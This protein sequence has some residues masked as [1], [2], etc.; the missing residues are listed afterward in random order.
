[1][2]QEKPKKKLL[3]LSW[4]LVGAGILLAIVGGT[5]AWRQ[6][7]DNKKT[8]RYVAQ[9]HF[10]A[11]HGHASSDNPS[12]VKP[13][14]DTFANWQVDANEPRYLFIPKIG[15][16]A[17]VRPTGL[18]GDGAIGTP[19]NIFDTDWYVGSAKPGQ[20]GAMLI[21]G[22]V[23]WGT[24]GVFYNLKK[25]Q[26]GD[27]ITVQRGDDIQLTY[28]V[29]RTHTYPADAVDMKQVLSPVTA[30]KPGLNLITC[31]GDIVKNGTTFDHRI[32]VFAEQL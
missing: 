10:R 28:R 4:L 6:W 22:H 13:S 16:K 21:D 14:A 15:V 7:Q 11:N 12:T 2:T 24:N 31:T 26:P 27:A 17:I 3:V 8:D 25:L 9:Q 19:N 5:L 1:M 20:A 32:V 29:V 30:G 23:S 18:T